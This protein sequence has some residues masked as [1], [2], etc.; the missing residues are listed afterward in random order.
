MPPKGKGKELEPEAEPAPDFEVAEDDP[1]LVEALAEVE[2]EFRYDEV[3]FFLSSYDDGILEKVQAQLQP[4]APPTDEEFEAAQ[5]AVEALKPDE[6]EEEAA[7][8][9]EDEEEEEAAALRAQRDAAAAALAALEDARRFA[10]AA[11]KL[12]EL[13]KEAALEELAANPESELA[14]EIKAVITPPEEESPDPKAK[15]GKGKKEEELLPIP[16]EYIGKMIVAGMRAVHDKHLAAAKAARKEQVIEYKKAMAEYEEL[17]AADR[18]AEEAKAAAKAERAARAEARALA[19]KRGEEVDDDDDEE[20]EDEDEEELDDNGDPIVKP[21][22]PIPKIAPFQSTTVVQWFA[23]K[24]W[25]ED[26][27]QVRGLLR[28]GAVLDCFLHFAEFKDPNAPA[29]PEPVPVKGGK[30]PSKGKGEAVAEPEVSLLDQVKEAQASALLGDILLQVAVVEI[31]N[32]RPEPEQPRPPTPPAPKPRGEDGE[33]GDEDEGVPPPPP[34][35]PEPIVWTPEQYAEARLKGFV[36]SLRE[37]LATVLARKIDYKLWR[38]A[39]ILCDVPQLRSG[40]PDADTRALNRLLEKIPDDL[41]SVPVFL[42]ALID[43]VSFTVALGPVVEAADLIDSEVL[44]LELKSHVQNSIAALLNGEPEPPFESTARIISA[45]DLA[46]LKAAVAEDIAGKSMENVPGV[47]A[48]MLDRITIPGKGREGMPMRGDALSPEERGL[49]E[50]EIYALAASLAEN[51]GV[52]KPTRAHVLH[53]HLL[54]VFSSL[55]GERAAAQGH[56]L[57]SNVCV[58]AFSPTAAVQV[59]LDAQFLATHSKS[60]YH[61]ETDQILLAFFE[62]VGEDRTFLDMSLTRSVPHLT[63]FREWVD[64]YASV[65]VTEAACDPLVVYSNEVRDCSVSMDVKCRYPSDSSVVRTGPN[66]TSVTLPS[67]VRVVMDHEATTEGGLSLV[68]ATFP[69][70]AVAS[71]EDDLVTCCTP[72][73]LHVELNTRTG[74]AFQKRFGL[75]EEEGRYTLPSGAQVVQLPDGTLRAYCCGGN[76]ATRSADGLLWVVTDN[77]GRTTLNRTI[78]EYET[79]ETP[80][81]AYNEEKKKDVPVIDPDTKEQVIHVETIEHRRCEVV[82]DELGTTSNVEDEDSG[83]TVVVREDL[84]MSISEP[85]GSSR[86]LYADRTEARTGAEGGITVSH[87]QYATVRVS[88][89]GALVVD[90]PGG[91][92]MSWSQEDPNARLTRSG[93]VLMQLEQESVAYG[94]RVV[95]GNEGSNFDATVDAVLSTEEEDDDEFVPRGSFTFVRNTACL[96]LND[97]VEGARILSPDGTYGPVEKPAEPLSRLASRAAPADGVGVVDGEVI[98]GEEGYKEGEG[99][100]GGDNVESGTPAEGE[101]DA[102]QEE[103]PAPLVYPPSHSPRLFVVRPDGSFL[104]LISSMHPA[105]TSASAGI[106]VTPVGETTT[107]IEPGTTDPSSTVY[108]YVTVLAPSS[109]DDSATR[110]LPKMVGAPRRTGPANRTAGKQTK[111]MTFRQVIAHSSPTADQLEVIASAIADFPKWQEAQ[112]ARQAALRLRDDRTDEELAAE[113]EVVARIRAEAAQALG[114][115]SVGSSQ[116][117]ERL[118]EDNEE[119]GRRAF[120]TARELERIEAER[121]ARE[122]AER[123]RVVFKANVASKPPAASYVKD[124]PAKGSDLRYFDA[125]EGKAFVQRGSVAIG[126]GDAD[127]VQGL[128]IHPAAEAIDLD[129]EEK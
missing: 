123:N 42:D 32:V 39:M 85:D 26:A 33:D 103:L 81:V 114:D 55:V 124:R 68:S 121:L 127:A 75:S 113:A 56:P 93:C 106:V 38:D 80:V 126:D 99:E 52:K 34:P 67:G 20:P 12:L 25:A 89:E 49:I 119:A 122:E 97:E 70:G 117:A 17:E 84:T 28:G 3:A 82:V 87:P 65:D 96:T 116:R 35:P 73:G 10:L 9:E 41:V 23:L 64:K 18:A 47:I 94:R 63:S 58:E 57:S 29:E 6:E 77:E 44:E 19:I 51:E 4:P 66:W 13:T 22:R 100:E 37:R 7:G 105:I 16:Q 92:T 128:D 76:V 112:I 115:S 91:G 74:V 40:S 129:D 71:A 101:G 111:L 108:T 14:L 46:G 118:V 59:Y 31:I 72:D 11:P 95:L 21:P 54:S 24:G 50:T 104:E 45:A 98:A 60:T 90:L 48:A 1:F 36:A 110:D 27:E 30:A 43:Q 120:A 61:S 5:A 78:L 53:Q 125:M 8:G 107:L 2:S 62:E 15:K 86:V 79:I 83:V 102:V 69:D 109:A 88:A